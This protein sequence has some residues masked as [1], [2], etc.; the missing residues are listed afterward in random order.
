MQNLNPYFRK[1]AA[2]KP[3]LTHVCFTLLMGETALLLLYNQPRR[4]S[5][6]LLPAFL[7]MNNILTPVV[8]GLGNKNFC[9]GLPYYDS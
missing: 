8:E 4:L 9:C 2:I 6:F 5:P 1:P 3:F 7:V